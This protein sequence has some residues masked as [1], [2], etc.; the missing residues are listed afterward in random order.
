MGG[1]GGGGVRLTCLDCNAC[2]PLL[3]RPAVDKQ[4]E[5]FI[6]IQEQLKLGKVRVSVNY[7][8]LFVALT[9]V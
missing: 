4:H 9:C 7:F 3:C 1:G 2:K 8:F 5:T 6:W